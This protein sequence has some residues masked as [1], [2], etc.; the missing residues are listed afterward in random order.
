MT[1]CPYEAFF[2]ECVTWMM[3]DAFVIELAK[4]LHDFFALTG[5]QV[6]R[7]FISEQKLRLSDDCP[8]NTYELLLAP[9]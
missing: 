3:C 5:M 9:R 7:G 4:E 6:S 2:S 8:G 1:R